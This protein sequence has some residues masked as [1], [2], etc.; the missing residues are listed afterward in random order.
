MQYIRLLVTVSSVVLSCTSCAFN[1]TTGK[2]TFTPLGA[3]VHEVHELIGTLAHDI[4]KCTGD[5]AVC[6]KKTSYDGYE[7]SKLKAMSNEELL[8]Y[9]EKQ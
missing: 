1:S 4:K 3:G 8:D 9:V 7:E 2:T 6:K 5:D